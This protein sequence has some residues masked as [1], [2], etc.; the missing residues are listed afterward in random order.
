M[1]EPHRNGTNSDPL[2]DHQLTPDATIAYKALGCEI[3]GLVALQKAMTEGLGEQFSAAVDAITRSEGRVIV[4]GVGKS[5]HIARKIAA[6]LSATGCPANFLQP[7][8]ASHGDLGMV[9]PKD[10][11]LALSWSGETAELAHITA[12]ARRYAVCLIASTSRRES[13]LARA[14]DY[15]LC[16]PAC[17]EACETSFAPTTSTT[18]QLALGDALAVALLQRGNV[19]V[20][21]LRQLH[22][23]GHLGTRMGTRGEE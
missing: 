21:T 16:L 23:A 8:E 5:G 4:T 18:M 7:S 15:V 10:V 11:L 3:A 22:P 12:Y 2:S 13:T 20:Q 19:P 17:V 14:A 9:T 1:T 6:T